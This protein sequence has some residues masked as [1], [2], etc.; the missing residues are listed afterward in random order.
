MSE[1]ILCQRD[2]A[3]ATVVLSNPAKRNAVTAAMWQRL[4]EVMNELSADTGLRCVIL[5]GAGKDFAAGGDIEEFARV[6]ATR[7][8]GLVYHEQWVAGALRAVDECLHPT[9]ALIRGNCIGG[10]LEIAALCDL[11]I[12]AHSAR[13]GAPINRLG[14]SMAHGELSGIVALVGRAVALEILLEGRLMGADEAYRKGLI[15]RVSADED[16]GEEARATA[17][18]IAA[19]APLVARAHK[20]LVRRLAPPPD[21]LTPQEIADSYAYFDSEDYRIGLKAFRDKEQPEFKG[22]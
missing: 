15:T 16:V 21:T 19:G 2:G 13:F 20:K 10:G 4:T 1:E 22:R 5:R 8:Q 9:V 11:R 17:L 14:F 12:A 7:E 6:R 3:I 18:R